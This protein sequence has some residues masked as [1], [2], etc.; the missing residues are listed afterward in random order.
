MRDT[1]VYLA[2]RVGRLL[3]ARG[4]KI[5]CAES[6]TG[7]GIAS[8]IT[9]IAGSSQWFEYGFVTYSNSAKTALLAVPEELLDQQGAVSEATV[10]AMARGALKSA[11]ADIAIAVSGIAG[12]GGATANKP[13]GSVW[14]CWHCADGRTKTA[15]EAFPGSRQAVREATVHKSLQGVLDILNE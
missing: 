6:C 14:H 4:Y 10:I 8:A 11:N 12:P 1:T 15:F 2:E 7:G 3:L 13:V 5:T 9:A